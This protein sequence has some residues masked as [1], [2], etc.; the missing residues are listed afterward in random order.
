MARRSHYVPPIV[1]LSDPNKPLPCFIEC[2]ASNSFHGQQF[3]VPTGV[4]GIAADSEGERIFTAT[5]SGA[6]N[7]TQVTGAGFDNTNGTGSFAVAILHD[8]ATYGIYTASGVTATTINISPALRATTTSK[9]LAALGGTTNGQ[10]IGQLGLKALARKIFATTQSSAYRIRYA[11]R[12]RPGPRDHAGGWFGVGGQSSGSFNFDFRANQWVSAGA[13]SYFH[14][15]GKRSFQFNPGTTN[16]RGVDRT[17]ALGGLSGYCEAFVGIQSGSGT[18]NVTVTVDAV[19]VY[20]QN[21]TALTRVIAPFT[22]GVSGNIAI[23]LSGVTNALPAVG[24]VTWWVYDR[25]NTWT[26]G[27]IDKNDTVVVVGD[28]WSTRYTSVLCTELQQA[29]TDAGGSGTV[30]S[31]GLSGMTAEWALHS[32]PAR[33]GTVKPNAVV[34]EYFV[35]DQNLYGEQN[36][37]RWLDNMYR[38]GIKCQKINARPIYVMP[39]PVAS[40]AQTGP[41]GDWSAALGS[42]LMIGQSGLPGQVIAL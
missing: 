1:T 14:A 13:G 34:I 15:R 9:A 33:I 31:A 11:D 7:D 22:N 38:L 20:N 36:V 24:D 40:S 5:V 37:A 32:F 30:T 18:M 28:S 10:H 12:W 26:N 41:F 25:S 16:G 21:I 6:T 3:G 4:A 2:W 29:M 19:P 35:N 27:V 23:T 17:V 39:I 8:D 42:G